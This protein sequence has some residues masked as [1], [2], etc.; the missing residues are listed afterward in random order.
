MADLKF[1]WSGF[2]VGAGLTM[3]V[4]SG[5]FHLQP[6]EEYYKEVAAKEAAE[7]NKNVQQIET[8]KVCP[9]SFD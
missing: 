9:V 7:K 8:A 5:L 1:W 6:K 4:L 3:V 2:L